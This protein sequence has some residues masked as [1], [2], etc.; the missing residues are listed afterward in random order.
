V[1]FRGAAVE[2]VAVEGAPHA[3]M[4][5]ASLLTWAFLAAHRD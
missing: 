3:W 4:D 5:D 2:L 1:P